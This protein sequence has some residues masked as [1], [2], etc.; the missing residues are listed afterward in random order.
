MIR[1]PPRD[2]PSEVFEFQKSTKNPARVKQENVDYK[3]TKHS[4][5]FFF[6]SVALS[7]KMKME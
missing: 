1:D 6:P 3:V 7:L 5:V 2:Y 4:L